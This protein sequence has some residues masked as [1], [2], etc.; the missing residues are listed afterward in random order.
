MLKP[1]PTLATLIS[2]SL[3][4][5]A[6][7]SFHMPRFG[8]PRVHKVTVQQG[9]VITQ[10]MIDR[11]KPGMTR[12]Q[13]VFVMGKPVVQNPFNKDRWDYVYSLRVPNGAS[14]AQ[15]VSLFFS[16]ERL[17][18]FTGDLAPSS[19]KKN[20]EDEAPSDAEEATAQR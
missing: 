16:N 13:V 7:S 1:L 9:N 2:I 18:Y 15:K 10:E 14:I 4:L 5:Q 11:L 3:V 6:C 20:N 12:S 19:E 8:I 17:A